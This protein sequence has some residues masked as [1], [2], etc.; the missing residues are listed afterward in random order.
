MLELRLMQARCAEYLGE[1]RRISRRI[2]RRLGLYLGYI[3]VQTW[4]EWSGG[5]E[6]LYEFIGR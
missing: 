4:D 2:S 5:D 3:S 1:S 6:S